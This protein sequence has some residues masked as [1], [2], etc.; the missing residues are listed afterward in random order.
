MW[1]GVENLS[2]VSGTESVCDLGY[3]QHVSME[4]IHF[5]GKLY[6]CILN[7]Q[8]FSILLYIDD[9]YI[10]CLNDFVVPFSFCL[11]VIQ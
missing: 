11:K 6:F 5:W 10:G 3:Y 2:A 9:F 1:V 8:S 4:R 7:C